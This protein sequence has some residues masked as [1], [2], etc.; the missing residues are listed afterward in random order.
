LDSV[1]PPYRGMRDAQKW[2]ILLAL[3][4]SQ[5][6]PLGVTA[7]SAWIRARVRSGPS[8]DWLEAAIPGLALAL[9]LYYGNGLLFGLHDQIRPSAYP[10]GWYQ[11][12]QV[13]IADPDPGRAVFLPWHR[14]LALSFVQNRNPVVTSPAPTFFSVPVV[15]SDDPEIPGFPQP[16][17]NPDTV[18]ISALIAAEG[19]KQWS[20]ALAARDIKYVILVREVDWAHYSYLDQQVGLERIIDNDSILLYRNA[21]WHK[22]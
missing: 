9:S 2:A 4:Y 8:R 3:A 22:R 5:A 7:L 14:Y 21:L 18:T 12:E 16:P 19:D 20:P 10:A 1:F 17:S 6:V 13:L 15:V 11:V